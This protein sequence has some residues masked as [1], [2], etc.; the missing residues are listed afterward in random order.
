MTRQDALAEGVLACKSLLGTYLP[1]FDDSNRTRQAPNLPNHVA[2]TLGHCAL[3]MHRAAE[4]FVSR[5]GGAGG[6]AGA[7]ALPDADFFRGSGTG[8]DPER[9]DTETV[10]FGSTP[11]DDPARYPRFARCVE[12]FNGAC[13]RLAAAVRGADDA[14]LDR[15]V[16]WG[17]RAELPLFLLVQRMIFHTGNHTGQIADLRR[18]LGLPPVL[19]ARR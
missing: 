4:K 19:L 3:T 11:A 13:D 10:A 15:V 2:W 17:A 1:G 5:A 14:T 7:G 6:A 12:V 8:G 16:A 18:A 9:F